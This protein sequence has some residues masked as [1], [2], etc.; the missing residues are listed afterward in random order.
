M[1][2]SSKK[3]YKRPI[4]CTSLLLHENFK[5]QMSKVSERLKEY[6]QE[7]VASRIMIFFSGYNRITK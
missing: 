2:I 4:I 6:E 5:S 3:I 7:N 1:D